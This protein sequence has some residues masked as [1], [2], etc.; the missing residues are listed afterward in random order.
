MPVHPRFA[1][2]APSVALTPILVPFLGIFGF[3]AAGTIP[4][5]I[6]VICAGLAAGTGGGAGGAGPNDEGSEA[7]GNED[8]TNKDAT[9]EDGTPGD[10]GKDTA[11]TGR[12]RCRDCKRKREGYC[13]HH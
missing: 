11:R 5:V 3:S 6:I 4:T 2:A 12:N 1:G 8:A 10:A 7:Q 13:L 9:D